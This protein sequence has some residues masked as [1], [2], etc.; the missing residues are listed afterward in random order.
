MGSFPENLI[1]QDTPA[2]GLNGYCSVV[3][4]SD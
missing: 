2:C 3:R 4:V 1:D